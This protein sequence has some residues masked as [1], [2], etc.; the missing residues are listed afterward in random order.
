MVLDRRLRNLH[1]LIPFIG[2]RWNRSVLLGYT[3]LA[4][5]KSSH[6]REAVDQQFRTIIGD[7]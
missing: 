1:S 5:G 2:N 7:G 6:A 4:V 3:D